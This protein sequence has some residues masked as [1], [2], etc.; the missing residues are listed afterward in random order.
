MSKL[1]WSNSHFD[2]V[3]P[4][5]D[6]LFHHLSCYHIPCLRENN[7]N[8]ILNVRNE[9][10]VVRSQ[11]EHAWTMHDLPTLLQRKVPAFPVLGPL[12]AFRLAT[13]KDPASPA[14]VRELVASV[15]AA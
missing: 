11:I 7:Q 13:S 4:R 6:Q 14:E 10:E 15:I 1:T 5:E 3:S 2:D 8:S 12:K 9:E